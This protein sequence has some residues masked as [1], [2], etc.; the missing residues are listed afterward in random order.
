[1]FITECLY[2]SSSMSLLNISC[3]FSIHASSLFL[4]SWIIFTIITLNFF[5]GSLP[6]TISFSWSLSFYL[7]PS[8]V[9]YYSVISF[10]LTYCVYGLLSSDCSI[11]VPLASVVCPL[12]SEVGPGTYV[13][14]L[15]R[16]TGACNLVRGT[17]S[18]PSD[19]QD[20]IRWC[21]LGCL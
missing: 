10:C 4:K 12:V 15:V 16:G 6:I 17:E 2:F 18:F 8:S 7:S 5:S 19:G 1:M 9:T 21:G 20:G 14:S 11:L 13:G 3:I